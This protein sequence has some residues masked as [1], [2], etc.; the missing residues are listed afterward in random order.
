MKDR[1]PT[2]PGRVKLVPVAGQTNVYDMTRADSPTQ[3]GTPL[4]KATLLQDATAALYGLGADAVPDEILSILSKAVLS[5]D[6]SLKDIGGNKVGT[7]IVTGSYIGT[8]VYGSSSKN[9][10]T[11]DFVPTFVYICSS[12]GN[13]IMAVPHFA[14]SVTAYSVNAGSTDC[15]DNNITWNGATMTWYCSSGKSGDISGTVYASAYNQMNKS[16]ETY[17]YF[18]I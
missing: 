10:L 7:R 4:N 8:G 1:V 16:G 15:G 6:G 9:T 13:Q 11:F 3:E 12:G 5:T 14:D 2:Y 18:Y 17:Y